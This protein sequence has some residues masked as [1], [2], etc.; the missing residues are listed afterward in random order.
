[1]SVIY[2]LG[3][4]E[5]IVLVLFAW[6]CIH[7]GYEVGSNAAEKKIDQAREIL[8]RNRRGVA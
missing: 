7:L 6:G 4:F 2:S 1:M 5:F 8:I 3:S